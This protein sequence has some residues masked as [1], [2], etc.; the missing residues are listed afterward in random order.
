MSSRLRAGLAAAGASL[1]LIAGALAGT[2]G[3]AADNE[4]CRPDG[5]YTTPGLNVPF[6]QVYDEAG[7]EKMG[8]DHPRRIIGY[9]T[10][11]RTGKNGQPSYLAKDIPWN[12]ITHINYAFAHVGS[13]NRISV[14]P[15]SPTNAA[16]GMEWPG[17]DT[18]DPALPYKGHFNLLNKYKKAN[19]DVKTLISVGG[20][21]ETGGYF[22]PSGARQPSGGFYTMTTNADGSTNTAGINAFADS[23]VDFIRKYGFN[24]VDVDYEYPT[25]MKDAG[26]PL[27]WQ[28]GNARRASLMKN[29]A[30]LMKTLRDKLN[31][32]SVADGKYYMLTVAAPSSGYLLRGMET[33]QVT[34]YLDYLNIM[35]YDLHGS[36]NEFVGPNAALYDD[37]KDAELAKW[38]VYN[39]AAYGGIGYLNTDWAY[40]YFRGAMQAGRINIGVPYY[41]RGWRNVTGGTNGLWGT[42][43]STGGCPIGLTTCGDGARGI[44]NLWHDK[45]NNTE[46]SGGGNPLWHAKNLQ[47]GRV[48]SYG[49]AYGLN[50]ANP[51]H[52]LTGTYTRH[53]DSTL[54]APWLWNSTKKVFLSTEDDQSIGVK[55]NYV[56]DR[57]IGGLMIWELAGD[58]AWDAAK[59]EWF[60]GNT[61]TSQMY[62]TLKTAAPYGATRAKV[63]VPNEKLDMNVEIGGFPIGDNNYPIT[64][65]LKITNKSTIT[66]P[67]GAEFQ[68]DYASSAPGTARDQSGFGVTVISNEHGTGN[69]IGGLKGDF[70]RISFKLRA[71]EPLAPGASLN[72][73]YIYYLPAP[74]PANFTVSFGGKTYG[75]T[76]DHARGGTIVNPTATPTA[77]P[78][79]DPGGCVAPPWSPTQIYHGGN[80]VSHNGRQWE[81]RWWTQNNEPGTNDVWKDLGA[82]TTPTS[83]PTITPT[84]TPTPT[85]TPT[86]TPTVDPTPTPTPTPTVTPT[87][88]SPAWKAGTAYTTGTRVSYAG[89]EYECRQPHTALAGWEPPNVAS[90]WLRL[91]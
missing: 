34:Q 6:C 42:A 40:H 83:T 69:N 9:F 16:T 81:A 7:R 18:L 89:V 49:P 86:I 43:K 4:S 20:W 66:I 25:S 54:V 29:Y 91:S 33:F 58:Y 85:P 84:V 36:W 56:K 19:P 44:D 5:L 32:A 26:H 63:N 51:E 50:P 2:A 65:K 78:T 10:S 60:M 79:V 67:G 71:N 30:I 74:S 27:D 12:K 53:Y 52:T 75:L 14:G 22:D 46:V 72:M 45:E 87:G 57:G 64:G 73:D 13:D 23:S 39:T 90:L 8:A 55:T 15:D 88:T 59:G 28:V 31:A 77:T 80:K 24:G 37:G 11:W 68:W 48:G 47:D 82:C 17:I 1:A 3:A 21:A 76:V 62:D 38:N 35:S 61:L 70:N 41:T